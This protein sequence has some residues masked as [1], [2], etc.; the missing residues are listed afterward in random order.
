MSR[1]SAMVEGAA[2]AKVEKYKMAAE[3]FGAEIYHTP[4]SLELVRMHHPNSIK[5][6]DFI[7]TQIHPEIED[8]RQKA[9]ISRF[10]YKMMS[11]AL[12][13]GNARAILRRCNNCH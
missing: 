12:Q 13:R 5:I 3:N 6:C 7:F 9:L 10:W 2:A 4:S 8:T 1:V 11:F